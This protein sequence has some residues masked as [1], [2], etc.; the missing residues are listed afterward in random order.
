MNVVKLEE[1]R[2]A[3]V[4]WEGVRLAVPAS[5]SKLELACVL[6]GLAGALLTD[7]LGGGAHGNG[8]GAAPLEV[9]ADVVEPG[10]QQPQAANRLTNGD[11]RGL[12]RKK[13]TKRSR[14]GKREELACGHVIEPVPSN[15]KKHKSRACEQC[16]AELVAT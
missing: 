6:Q 3:V 9:E 4:E 15:W 1:A 2:V 11:R 7:A 8:N 5:M 14:D 12:P 13:V 16:A 10:P